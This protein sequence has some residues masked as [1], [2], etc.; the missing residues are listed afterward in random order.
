MEQLARARERLTAELAQNQENLQL[1]TAEYDKL[2]A[3]QYHAQKVLE[4][5]AADKGDPDGNRPGRRRKIKK[6][7]GEQAFSSM[8]TLVM[9]RNRLSSLR[10]E[11]DRLHRQ[12]E[13]LKE[14]SMRQRLRWRTHGRP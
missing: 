3:N 10:Q 1:V 12:Q 5:A 11:Q 6:H 14:R 9:T 4:K 2:E 13:S 8:Q 7:I